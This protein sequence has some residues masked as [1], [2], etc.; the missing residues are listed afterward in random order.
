MS[1]SGQ[2]ALDPAPLPLVVLRG[3]EGDCGGEG[4]ERPHGHDDEVE[5]V[6]LEAVVEDGLADD[7]DGEQ[8]D[9]VAQRDRAH[10]DGTVLLAKLLSAFG[11]EESREV[12]L[13]L[14][15]NWNQLLAHETG[16]NFVVSVFQREWD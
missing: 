5:E 8:E 13:T 1:R 3:W 2:A 12:E 4:D 9:H 11:C 10:H 6:A 7:A 16:D 14:A 15:K